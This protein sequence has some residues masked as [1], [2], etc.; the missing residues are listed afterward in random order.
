VVWWAIAV[1]VATGF[2]PRTRMPR[3]ALV[4]IAGFGLLLAL[5]AASL[6]WTASAEMTTAE[7]A[8]VALY[9]GV[10]VLVLAVVDRETWVA[11][12][13]AVGG[14]A[15]IVALA[16][17]VSRLV[18]GIGNQTVEQTLATS[19]L[20]YPLNYWNGV[21]AWAAIAAGMALV[22]SAHIR[23]PAGRALALAC[24]PGCVLAVY[25]T[26]SRA[27]VVDLV[28]ALGLVLL[29]GRN[30]WTAA[31]HAV[32]AGVATAA[33]AL[34]VRG[35][36]AIADATGTDGGATVALALVAASAVCAVGAWLTARTGADSRW[37]LRPQAARRAAWAGVA[38]ACG[39]IVL[40][41]ATG[42]A[43]RA[44]NE[45]KTPAAGTVA[46]DPSARLA[47]LNSLRYE[48]WSA[49]GDAWKEHPLGGIGPGTYEFWWNRHATSPFSVRDAHSLYLENLAE[50]GVGGLLAV[51]L[52]AGGLLALGIA[53]RR[54]LRTP[55]EVAAH[56]ALLT[57]AIVFLTHAGIDWLWETTALALLGLVCAAAVAAPLLDRADRRPALA[58]R[59]S[60]VL[61]ALALC[62][63]ELPGLAAAL[64]ERAATRALADGNVPSAL[65]LSNDAVSAEPWAAG[66]LALR[67]QVLQRAG[68][69]DAA[70]VD[71]RRAIDAE[72]DNWRHW[73]VLAR[74]ETASGN[75]TAALDAL[76]RARSLNPLGRPFR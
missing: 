49:A 73:F 33:V 31:A 2:L 18:P 61:L 21:G 46:S 32:L 3:A 13:A 24:V 34:V 20:S 48:L 51:L 55:P 19:R 70:R 36:P 72:P 41:T 47:N 10:V 56:A 8:R 25:L 71:L 52:V 64:R 1:G 23:R 45:F 37:R 43:A 17:T 30:R 42:A 44:W 65:R 12:A 50:L 26:Y 69:T 15:V 40:V 39:A 4:P 6:D 66:P 75:T 63:V 68:R 5:T 54:K 16:S 29:L 7:L 62:L 76:A 11:V 53:A 59:V 74:L 57:A 9:A 67:A 27:S 28:L 35:E 60:V 22:A 14:V 38:V 58:W